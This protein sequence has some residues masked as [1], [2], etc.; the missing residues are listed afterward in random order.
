MGGLVNADIIEDLDEIGE[1]IDKEVTKLTEDVK[2]KQEIGR[3]YGGVCLADKMCYH[4]VS[5]CE[6]RAGITSEALG[7]FSLDGKVVQLP[8]FTLYVVDYLVF[9]FFVAADADAGKNYF[10]GLNPVDLLYVS[11]NDQET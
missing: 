7:S 10:K 8:G 9:F 3:F 11:V 1:E 4:P 2:L 6:R 5:Y